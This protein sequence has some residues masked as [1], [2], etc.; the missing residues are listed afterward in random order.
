MCV[1]VCGYRYT[2]IAKHFKAVENMDNEI[3]IIAIW[4]L[5]S[6]LTTPE[7]VPKVAP[8]SLTEP[9]LQQKPEVSVRAKHIILAM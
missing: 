7:P 2:L 9:E 3:E 4:L 1:C 5:I 6:N 8:E